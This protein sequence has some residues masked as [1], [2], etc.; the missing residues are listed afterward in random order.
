MLVDSGVLLDAE[1]ARRDD[2]YDGVCGHGGSE[3]ST[4]LTSLWDGVCTPRRLLFFT[5]DGCVEEDVTI[6]ARLVSVGEYTV[7]QSIR[8]ESCTR[9][10][11]G[12][13]AVV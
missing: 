1:E 3:G 2:H 12:I 13:R 11:V 9:L 5:A 4:P 7:P 8:W 10:L 6:D